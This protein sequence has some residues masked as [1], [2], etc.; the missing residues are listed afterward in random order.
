MTGGRVE[1]GLGAGGFAQA[2]AAMGEEARQP[3]DAVSALEEAIPVIRA[4]WSGRKGARVD[5]RY[6]RL[7]GVHAGPAPVHPIGI[8]IGA[9]G[10]RML[11][12]TGR[13]ADGWLPSLGRMPLD[14]LREANARIDEAAAGAGRDPGSILR[15]C[16]IGGRI[17]DGE[18]GGFL[19]GPADQWVEQLTELAVD[20][21]MDGF[22]S[23]S[24][25]DP[26]DHLRRLA[27]EI[28]PRVRENVAI[29]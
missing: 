27:T 29:P 10:P 15:I 21:G 7:A 19:E 22:I 16:N 20:Y 17:T 24:E 13:S 6:Y 18:A 14:W 23:G 25:D 4:M 9:Y 11:A 3:R 26:Q 5:G 28:A 8:W 12:I 2:V 1:L